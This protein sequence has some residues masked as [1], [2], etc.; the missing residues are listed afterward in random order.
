MIKRILVHTIFIILLIA[1][2]TTW[3]SNLMVTPALLLVFAIFS[4]LFE[5]PVSGGIYGLICG[6]MTDTFSGGP[7]FLNTLLFL[8]VC[9]IVGV[10]SNRVISKTPVNAVLI[11][12]AFT[13]SY[14]L[15]YYFFS[16]VI[17]G[18]G[19]SF[20]RFIVTFA[21][22]VGFSGI[23]AMVLYIPVRWSF[24]GVSVDL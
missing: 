22:F 21:L 14:F 19:Y 7:A 10:V 1:L 15:V 2:Q 16:L 8:Y 4:A 11:T 23:S 24:R 17:W 5:G 3:L 9:V 13:A 20:L 12:I 18:E 6:V